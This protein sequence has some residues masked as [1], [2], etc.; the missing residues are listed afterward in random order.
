MQKSRFILGLIT[1]M[2]KAIMWIALAALVISLATSA[3][4]YADNIAPQL[5]DTLAS[6]SKTSKSL[7]NIS[8]ALDKTSA[9]LTTTADAIHSTLVGQ[10]TVSYP[11]GDGIL[12]QSSRL[13]RATNTLLT[14]AS[15]T[16]NIVRHTSMDERAELKTLTDNASLSV[17]AIGTTVTKVG[18]GVDTLNTLLAN[19]NG[20]TVPALTSTVLALRGTVNKATDL[21]SDPDITA[22]GKNLSLAS[23][24]MNDMTVN[25]NSAALHASNALGFVE[26]DLSPKHV[27]FWQSILSQGLS[28]AIGIPLKY[29]PTRVTVVGSVPVPVI[30]K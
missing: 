12:Y 4:Y 11:H 29:F 28:Q 6:A 2:A 24:H 22:V 13:V 20:S 3:V 1:D 27:S 18:T 9:S 17:A 10:T 14:Q 7:V 21:L 26:M 19:V 23:G 5:S 8:S 16:T 25:L 15:E 30:V